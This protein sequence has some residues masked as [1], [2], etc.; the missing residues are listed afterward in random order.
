[1]EYR[2]RVLNGAS[3]T[4]TV[5]AV[6]RDPAL[7]ATATDTV[8]YARQATTSYSYNYGAVRMPQTGVMGDLFQGMEASWRKPIVSKEDSSAAMAAI[9]LG[10]ASIGSLF[11]VRKM[12]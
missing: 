1:M 11:A 10:I 7:R 2:V 3:V 6:S 8:G 9:V 5:T 4:S 12:V